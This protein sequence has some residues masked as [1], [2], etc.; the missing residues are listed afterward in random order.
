MNDKSPQQ[1][2]QN[3]PVVESPLA[4]YLRML[5]IKV[6]Q[7][8]A[9]S[10]SAGSPGAGKKAG[11]DLPVGKPKKKKKRKSPAQKKREKFMYIAGGVI[12]FILLLVWWGSQPLMGTMYYGI[13]K[14]LAEQQ[15]RYPH[16]LQVVSSDGY[17]NKVRIFYTFFDPF[18]QYKMDRIECTFALTADGPQSYYL[19]AAKVNKIDLDPEVLTHFNGSVPAILDNPPDLAL[20]PAPSENLEELRKHF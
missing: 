20:P 17:A 8:T 6:P 11:V 5:G 13:C 2:E 1:Q 4:P 15:L 3:A 14:V 7:A 12:G 16:T 9:P 10:G 18:G 19:Q